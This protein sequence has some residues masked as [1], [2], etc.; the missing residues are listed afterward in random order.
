MRKRE[1]VAGILA[2][3]AIL[4]AGCAPGRISEYARQAQQ[5]GERVFEG[6]AVAV[7]QEESAEVEGQQF[8]AETITAETQGTEPPEQESGAAPGESGSGIAEETEAVSEGQL[9][10]TMR[11]AESGQA[12]TAD[13]PEMMRQVPERVQEAWARQR[14]AF[15]GHLVGLDRL[16]GTEQAALA[17]VLARKG[18]DDRTLCVQNSARFDGGEY[19][20][21][22]LFF[23]SAGTIARGRV[24]GDLWYYGSQGA[25]QLLEDASFLGAETVSEGVDSWFLLHTQEEGS[26]RARMYRV[27]GGTCSSLFE[28]AVSVS[29]TADGLCVMRPSL[30]FQYDPEAGEW[31]RGDGETP[32][33]YVYDAE[34]KS[35][36]PQR[37]RSLTVQEYL[38]Y[39]R[40]EASDEE[41]LA[42]RQAQR[43]LFF[44]AAEQDG[45]C[46]YTFF[47]VGSDR[48]GYRERRIGTSSRTGEDR[49]T[50]RYRYAIFELVGGQLTPDSP[51]VSGEGYWF[52]DPEN[53][54]EELA[55]LNELPSGLLE[56]RISLAQDT[57]RPGEREAFERVRQLENYPAD[58][59]VF[60]DTA[61][62]DG[63]GEDES[64]VAAG[65]YDGA[66]GA[67]VCDLWY[68]TESDAQLLEEVLPLRSVSR[69]AFGKT[70]LYLL[71]GY[72]KD[73]TRDLLYCVQSGQ[74]RRL[75][76]SAGRI[77]V[78]ENGDLIAWDL[79]EESNPT[80]FSYSEGTA[81]EYP[82]RS[83]S[84]EELL[85]FENGRPV[86]DSLLRQVGGDPGRL[87]CIRQDNGLWHVTAEAENGALF[88][89][90]WKERDGALI[91]FDCGEGQYSLRQAEE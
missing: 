40:P 28:D 77:E 80:Y 29:G 14:E 74:A 5:A 24:K 85:D 75:L 15:S 25:V 56:S 16:N 57:M 88:Y 32:G 30:Y 37:I 84:P 17:A 42:F 71:K 67:P 90:T 68:V 63:D 3:T 58:G 79:Q 23:D 87:T 18:Y 66:F 9:E 35:F 55:E 7:L 10:E 51:S 78:E 54:E 86:Y 69:Y 91:L 49:A 70:S 61:D 81:T 47:A 41:G 65:E 33:Y 39:I 34:A 8:L 20:S 1:A 48:I 52:S 13:W 31:E 26:Q 21:F 4:A 38:A 45:E 72:E 62:Y 50:A 46:D 76:E 11:A 43:D 89:E 59:L 64:F 60:V 2:M 36:I 53:P 12:R 83:A 19:G 27:Q 82:A 22:L 6:E 73:G 44:A